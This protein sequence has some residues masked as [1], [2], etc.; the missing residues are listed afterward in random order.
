MSSCRARF[1]SLSFAFFRLW[2]AKFCEREKKCSIRD[3]LFRFIFFFLSVFVWIFEISQ[4]DRYRCT[5]MILNLPTFTQQIFSDINNN[6]Y[7]NTTR[8]I[9]VFLFVC[10]FGIFLVRMSNQT[11]D[12]TT[13]RIRCTISVLHLSKNNVSGMWLCSK[14][15]KIDDH[16]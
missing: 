5:Q 1:T 11:I 8:A 7:V 9:I 6:K 15:W 3:L 12:N 13:H 14:M 10:G 16:F 4:L 2:L